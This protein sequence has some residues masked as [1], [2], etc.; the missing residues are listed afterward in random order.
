MSDKYKAVL[1]PD[2]SDLLR[3]PFMIFAFYISVKSELVLPY[4]WIMAILNL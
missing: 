4:C 1:F 3:L 2:I